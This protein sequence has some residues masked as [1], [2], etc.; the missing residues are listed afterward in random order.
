MR[1]FRFFI[2]LTVFLAITLLLYVG[3][4]LNPREVPSPLINRSAPEFRLPRLLGN[5]LDFQTADL[6]GQVWILNV[7]ASWC[8]ACRS[9]HELLDELANTRTVELIGL[10]YKDDSVQAV[11]WLQT[12]GNPY[13]QIAVDVSGNVAIDWG[14]YGVPE[15][16]V[17]DAGGVIRY[18]HVGPLNRRI[19]KKKILPLVY[20]L[21]QKPG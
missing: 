20:R 21:S 9:E 11:S 12:F 10:N 13:S 6:H 8:A 14:V 2:P 17:I 3:L 1:F 16:F 18:K 7:W 15:T 4:Q 19:L 5:G